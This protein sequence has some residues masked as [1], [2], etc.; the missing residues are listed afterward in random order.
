[1]QQLIADQNTELKMRARR[2]RIR[3]QTLV[4]ALAFL[5]FYLIGTLE[6]NCQINNI[7]GN[8]SI[9]SSGILVTVF[10]YLLFGQVIDNLQI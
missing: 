4:L 7:T 3:W 10:S 6:L 2:R 9:Q 5:R 1:M 8:Q